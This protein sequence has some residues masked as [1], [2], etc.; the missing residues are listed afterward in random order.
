M[1]ASMIPRQL[2]RAVSRRLRGAAAGLGLCLALTGCGGGGHGGD[3][4]GP[5]PPASAIVGAAGGTVT[6]AD[7]AAVV[8]PAGA[9]SQDTRITLE[10]TQTGAPPLPG[11]SVAAGPMFAFTP[12]GTAFAAPVTV[13]L[14][15]DAAS[16]PAG[17]VPTLLKT[18]AGQADWVTVPAT[19]SGTRVS[20]QVTG[21]SFL[22]VV[23]PPIVRGQPTRIWSFSHLL[24]DSLEEVKAS[25][26][27]QEGGD[28]E[29]RF[30]HGPTFRDGNLVFLDGSTL[31]PDGIATGQIA[32]TADGITYF[33]GAEAPRAAGSRGCR[34][35]ASRAWC[36][37]KA[38]SSDRRTPR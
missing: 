25:G 31:P 36:R 1:D 32:S 3:D 33:V 16:V 6:H 8:V 7:G 26:A 38:S 20:A 9:L 4:G 14:P 24:G 29:V 28:L 30:D 22:Q 10:P 23:V 18:S 5:T 13:T 19:V 37:C 17:R 35:A 27:T 21:F 12:H 2:L 34:S 15:F 11:G